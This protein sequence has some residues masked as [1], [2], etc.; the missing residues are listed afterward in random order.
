[1]VKKA[2]KNSTDWRENKELDRHTGRPKQEL[3]YEVAGKGEL[4]SI[5][6]SDKKKLIT[7]WC[8]VDAAGS[9]GGGYVCFVLSRYVQPQDD[10]KPQHLFSLR[11]PRRGVPCR[12]A[13]DPTTST[14]VDDM[15]AAEA[16]RGK[17]SPSPTSVV[18]PPMARAPSLPASYDRA[19]SDGLRGVLGLAAAGPSRMPVAEPPQLIPSQMGLPP[20]VPSQMT[21]QQRQMPLLDTS[22]PIF[23][24]VRAMKCLSSAVARIVS[25]RPYNSNATLRAHADA[26]FAR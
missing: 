9:R 11:T 19:A 10:P 20:P 18:A 4:I 5:F 15:E 17:P 26:H 22:A 7:S 14:T 13:D 3:H 12:W 8:R 21:S 24:H 23:S 25:P 2:K 6:S 16:P 1:M